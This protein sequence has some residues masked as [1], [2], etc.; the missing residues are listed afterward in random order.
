MQPRLERSKFKDDSKSK[1][2]FELRPGGR[3]THRPNARPDALDHLRQRGVRRPCGRSR[4]HAMLCSLGQAIPRA[5]GRASWPVESGRFWENRGSTHTGRTG[6][7]LASTGGRAGAN[8]EPRRRSVASYQTPWRA[9]PRERGE[10][11]NRP[12]L[13]P[14]RRSLVAA[15]GHLRP[16][17]RE[18]GSIGEKQWRG[19]LGRGFRGSRL[20]RPRR[21]CPENQTGRVA[22]GRLGSRAPRSDDRQRRAG[23]ND[24]RRS[25][26]AAASDA[27]RALG[28]T[29]I[30]GDR[31]SRLERFE[32]G[33]R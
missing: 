19:S 12:P 32:K 27:L 5:I 30:A 23:R 31:P 28:H 6:V 20:R 1:T 15:R 8:C 33:V 24:F 3:R 26:P 22:E 9:L 14:K 18:C 10:G 2:G 17:G 25:N 29:G 7:A 13:R 11:S 21:T 4:I 16:S